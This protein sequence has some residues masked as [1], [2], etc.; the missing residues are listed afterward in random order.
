MNE[1]E[2]NIKHEFKRKEL[3]KA[4]LTHASVSSNVGKNYERLEFLGDRVLGVT[5]AAML[6][7]AFPFEPEGNL[8]QRFVALVCKETVSE[9]ARKINLGQFILVAD[10]E[11]RD[12]D[13]V[14]CD[15]CEALIGAI[16]LDSGIDEAMEFVRS[17]W[18]GLIDK[19]LAPPKDAK[20]LLQEVAHIKNLGAP[21]YEIIKRSG[22]EHDPVF[23][24]EVRLNDSLRV[25]GKGHSKKLAEFAAATKMLELLDK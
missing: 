16:Y 3:L 8:S 24:V 17:C 23:T 21:R 15:A 9:V 13:N 19:K 20:T 14:L 2:Q 25:C 11:I 4:A 18:S 22:L 1:L 7:E 10:E 5:V 6:Y 12:S